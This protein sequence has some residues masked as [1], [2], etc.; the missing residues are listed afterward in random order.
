MRKGRYF[1]ASAAVAMAMVVASPSFAEPIAAPTAAQADEFVKKAEAELAAFGNYE[2]QVAWVKN[3]YITVDTDALATRA[4]TESTEMRVRL[5]KQAALYKT[6]PGLSFDTNRKLD[7]LRDGLTLAAP[8]RPGAAAELST[9]STR[10]ESAYGTGKGTYKGKEMPGNDL[11]ALMGTERDPALLAEM[12]TSWHDK[13]GAPM[14]KDYQ[15]M[16]E[17]SNE[18]ARAL[19]YADTG[20]MW[21]AGYDMPP[22]QFS[23]MVD[24]LWGQVKP[25]YDALHCYT[26]GKLNEKYGDVVQPKTGPIRADILGNM[27]AQDWSGIYDVVAPKGIGNIGYDVGD[28]LKAKGMD[29]VAMFKQGEKFYTSLGFEPLPKTFWERSM[30]VR[31]RDREVMCHASA[32][33]LDSVDDL[34]IKMCTK[35]NGTDFVTIH[36]EMGHN[37]YQRAYN[38]QDFLYR[39]GANDGFHEAI[40]DFVALSVMP[41]Y[42]VQTGL[43]DK[44]KVPPPSADIGLLLHQ[45]LEKVPGLPWTLLVDKWRWDV[46]SGKT[47]PDAY[48]KAWTDIRLHYMGIIPPVARNETDFDPGAKMHIASSVPYARYF[49]A[50]LYQFQFYQA[51][52]NQIGWK[53]PLHRCTFYNRPEVGAKFN[54]MLKMGQSRPWPEALA[55]FTGKTEMDGSAITAYFKPLMTWLAVQNKGKQCGW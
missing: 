4:G 39:N 36:H 45:A 22:E 38:K 16:V 21:R 47:A 27:W 51:A 9:I 2:Q 50:R 10:M 49:L 26:R 5:A 11:E 44:S 55:A 12:W 1:F 46:F 6:A 31:P 19:G 17:I 24:K 33:D 28:L 43:L 34:R 8:D 54:A 48:N 52:C 23:A 25:L 40:G 7:F 42:L 32:W 14:R 18:G 29:E 41:D 53:G 13:V 37:F 30:I 20:A 35:V 3:T 15:R